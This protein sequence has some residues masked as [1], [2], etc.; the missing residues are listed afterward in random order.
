LSG[1]RRRARKAFA[2][3]CDSERYPRAPGELGKML[4]ARYRTAAEI[5]NSLLEAATRL[6]AS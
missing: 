1:D 4:R 3:W 5:T 2:A 6:A